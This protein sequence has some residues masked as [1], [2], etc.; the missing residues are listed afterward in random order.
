MARQIINVGTT[1]NDG[2]GDD[3]R[4]GGVKINANFQELYANV[5][6]LQAVSGSLPDGLGFTDRGILFEGDSPADSFQTILKVINPTADNTIYLPDDSGEIALKTD[7]TATIDSAYIT[8]RTGTT[9]DSSSVLL[10][11]EANSLDSDRTSALI[12]SAYIQARQ[13]FAFSSLTGAPT[14]L[15][16]AAI[17]VFTLD[18][19]LTIQLIDSAYV[20]GRVSRSIFLDSTYTTA[21]IDS[22]YVQ[23]RASDQALLT[24]SGPTFA[25]LTINGSISAT[26]SMSSY[27]S[28]IQGK[29]LVIADSATNDAQADNAGIFVRSGSGAAMNYKSTG[30]K[31]EFNRPV[32]YDS[33]RLLDSSL[34]DSDYV[35]A[36]ADHLHLKVYS[37]ATTPSGT[38]GEVIFVNDGDS[39][40]PCLA[41]HD[42]TN[43][44]RIELGSVITA[45]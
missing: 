4:T 43:W 33:G 32:F 1:G 24:T 38:A 5:G 3:L 21:L 23:D 19:D 16:S 15:D 17:Q 18:S 9:T 40:I 30:D 10:L 7:I 6:N 29:Y 37:V 14:V 31:W 28:F 22:A 41:V 2:T 45:T 11:I 35:Q 8:F 25:G 12:D 36:R 26:G 27:S 34:V 44:K 13:D 42:G 39:G 20:T